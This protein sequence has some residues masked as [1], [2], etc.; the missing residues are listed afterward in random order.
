[1]YSELYVFNHTCVLI[2]VVNG[3]S[4]SDCWLKKVNIV[5]LKALSS[6]YG[7][8]DV[9]HTATTKKLDTSSSYQENHEQVGNRI[10]TRSLWSDIYM[11]G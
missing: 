7:L 11:T 8:S 1:M 3:V 9:S 6:V 2:Y 10:L 4:V 5:M